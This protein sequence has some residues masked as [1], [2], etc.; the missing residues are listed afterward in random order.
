[1]IYCQTLATDLFENMN[2]DSIEK[3]L[4]L[5][6]LS[7]LTI[8]KQINVEDEFYLI[9]DSKGKEYTKNFPYKNILTS[10]DRYPYTRPLQMSAYKLYSIELFSGKSFVHFDND[11]FLFKPIP[12]FQDTLVQSCEDIF[13]HTTYV[14]K[15]Q[16]FDWKFPSYINEIKKNYNPGI[17]GFN[18]NSKIRDEYYK[19][20]LEFYDKNVQFIK[21]EECEIKKNYHL[22]DMQDVCLVLEEGLLWYLCNKKNIDVREFI[23]NKY[24]NYENV[25]G[26]FFKGKYRGVNWNF[27]EGICYRR[28]REE[29]YIH[30][31]NY[32]NLIN[33]YKTLDIPQTV[34]LEVYYMYKEEVNRML[35]G[36]IWKQ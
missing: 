27:I 26:T 33:N 35:N 19:I 16:Y 10:L 5:H 29:K 17:F 4:S 15:I 21:N 34:F 36:E 12:T 23:Q 32:P 7:A 24:S 31:M 18:Y 2:K 8:S 28:W 30:L 22:K 6:Y 3:I 13:V 9:T 11:V 1:M 14:N 25:W 20:F